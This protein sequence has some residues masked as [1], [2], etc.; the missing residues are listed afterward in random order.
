V[1][2]IVLE[3]MNP[4]CPLKTLAAPVEQRKIQKCDLVRRL[5][6]G[7]DAAF[8]ELIERYKSKVYRAAY[9][10]LRN[11]EDADEIAQETFAK[12]YFSIN[13]FNGRSSLFTW[14]YRIAVNEC[15]SYLRKKRFKKRL[16][17]ISESDLPEGALQTIPDACPTVD[18]EV[19]RRDL[20][21]KA[22]AR[23]PED[24]RLLL[25]WREVEGLS[26]VEL[27]ELIGIKESTLKVKLF[28]ARRKLVEATAR[29]DARWRTRASVISGGLDR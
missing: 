13:G 26:M 18:E 10:I 17:L 29:L 21:N 20:I 1:N 3:T 19:V 12:V 15:Y 23:L 7:D 6:T 27:S 14:I 9:G 16:K 25:L 22:L 4:A 28:R 5:R 2:T 8:R 24:D 11:P